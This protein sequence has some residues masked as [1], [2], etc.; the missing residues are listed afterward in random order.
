MT[1]VRFDPSS[2]ATTLAI[3]GVVA[4]SSLAPPANPFDASGIPFVLISVHSW[5]E[6]IPPSDHLHPDPE[7]HL[8]GQS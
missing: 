1:P 3:P 7:P 8:P 5:L 6:S 4:R 2:V